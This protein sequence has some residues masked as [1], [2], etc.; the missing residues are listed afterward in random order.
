MQYKIIAPEQKFSGVRRKV[1]FVNGVGKTDDK[2]VTLYFQEK[3][4]KIKEN[5]Q[6]Q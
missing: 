6:N 3:G 2:N 5:N 1:V 4:Y